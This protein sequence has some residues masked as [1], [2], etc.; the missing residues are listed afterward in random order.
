MPGKGRA[1]TMCY[2]ISYDIADDRRRAKVHAVL[3]GF[4]TW[5]QFSLF[6]CF[7]TSKELVL[8]Q[9]RLAK[10]I[11]HREDTV[12]IYALCDACCGRIEILG[13]GEPP[14]EPKVFM[15]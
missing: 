1:A 6:E 10:I 7:L 3:S 13:H 8:L 5:T 14:R 11:H 15:I 12:R 9:A 2:V 4:G